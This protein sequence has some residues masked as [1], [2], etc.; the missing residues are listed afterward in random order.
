M[1]GNPIVG[2]ESFGR[3]RALE[4][5][6]RTGSD[7]PELA[8]ATIAGHPAGSS[9]GGERP[10]FGVFVDGRHV[11]VTFAARAFW[12]RASDDGR[13]SDDLR[14]VGAANRGALDRMSDV[15]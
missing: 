13:L 3:W 12:G 11:L 9:A 15:T 4:T 8:E 2:D 7:Y 6:A 1:P 14:S 5:V 10:T